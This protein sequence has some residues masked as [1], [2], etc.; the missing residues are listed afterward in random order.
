MQKLLVSAG[1]FFEIHADE[2]FSVQE[3]KTEAMAH[4]T[5]NKDKHLANRLVVE[6]TLPEAKAPRMDSS[7]TSD[8]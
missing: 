5:S 6:D 2:T 7:A 1:I 4:F 3:N 8:I